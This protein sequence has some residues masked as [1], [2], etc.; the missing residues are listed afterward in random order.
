MLTPEQAASFFDDAP[1]TRMY[2]TG[3]EP[4]IPKSGNEK[5]DF[6]LA[7]TLAKI[8]DVFDVLPGFAYYDDSDGLNAYATPAVRLNR[9]DGTVLFGQRLLNRLMSGPENPDASV[10]A[11][12][13]HEFGHIVQHRKGLT[14]NL[15]AGQPTVKRAELQADFFAG[16]FAGVRKL[17]RANFPAAVFAMTQYNFGDNMINNPSHHG[18]PPERSDAITAGFKTAFTEKK[19]FAEALV[20]ATNYV[21]QL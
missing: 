3:S 21:M 15:L 10:A 11:V 4:M 6:A 9:S 8:S 16:Y 13:A 1:D 12:C 5:L 14:Q 2:I 20:S 19:S 7:Q 18:T 17:Q